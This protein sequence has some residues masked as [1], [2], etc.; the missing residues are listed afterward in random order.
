MRRWPN[1]DLQRRA[2]A[3]AARPRRR[4]VHRHPRCA[5][6][7]PRGRDP[8]R[9]HVPRGM[10]E[11]WVDLESPYHKPL[12]AR[13]TRSDVLFCAMGWRSALGTKTLQEMGRCPVAHIEGGFTAWK[14]FG[15]PVAEKP[16]Q[17]GQAA[18]GR[19]RLRRSICT[20]TCASR[21]ARTACHNHRLDA[22]AAPLSR[23]DFHAPR[24]SFFPSL[25]ADAEPHP[26]GRPVLRRC[27]ARRR[28]LAR[29][30]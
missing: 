22:A 15:A 24:T 11:F 1:H 17:G 5:R 23:A 29:D 3:R 9:F 12:F 30:P 28:W 7:R 13:R 8:G 4:A 19:V 18:E 16:A 25:A 26:G 27:A 10:L 6:A 21:P 20:Q 14:A 2:G